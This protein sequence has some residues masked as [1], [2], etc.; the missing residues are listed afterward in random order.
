MRK[1]EYLL[2]DA[3]ARGCSAVVTL[4]AVG[5]NHVLAA[6][7]HAP[8]CGF[9]V[10]AAVYPRPSG[11]DTE[12]AHRAALVRG[13]E[14]RIAPSRATLPAVAAALYARSALRGERP[15]WIP[16]GGSSAAGT[17]GYVAA[18]FE[19]R[20]QIE[21]GLLPVPERVYLALGSGGTAAGLLAGFR[22]AGMA[23]RVVAVRAARRSVANAGTVAAL[24]DATLARLAR[25]GWRHGAAPFRATDL[26]VIDDHYGDGYGRSTPRAAE[27]VALAAE[28]AGLILEETY[29][30][31][32]MAGLIADLRAGAGAPRGPVLFWQTYG[33]PRRLPTPDAAD[34]A[35]P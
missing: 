23:T 21:E 30:G 4:G 18:A 27:A 6:A 35:H 33:D 12:L 15:C 34:A 31:K 2:G 10:R 19:L 22:L 25:H 11:R 13:A 29:T 20:R 28:T 14:V 5:S 32:A 17:V 3:R 26:T 8:R 24:A 7:V 1:L 9:R 16:A